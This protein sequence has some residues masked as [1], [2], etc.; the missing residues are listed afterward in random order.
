MVSQVKVLCVNYF[1]VDSYLGRRVHK[2]SNTRFFYKKNFYKKMSLKN[3]K[4]LRKCK[5]NLQPQMAELQFSKT[6]IFPG[7]L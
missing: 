1:M 7:A 2:I 4:T 6:L 5:E 3:P